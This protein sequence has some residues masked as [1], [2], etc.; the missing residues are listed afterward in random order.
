MASDFTLRDVALV[1]CADAATGGRDLT[2]RAGRLVRLGP[3]L[4]GTRPRLYLTPGFWDAHVHMLHVGLSRERLDLGAAH[5][6]EEALALLR[7]YVDEHPDRGVVW[8]EGWD[9]HAWPERRPPERTEIDAVVADR[10]VIFRRVCGHLAVLNSRA[11]EEAALRWPGLECTGLLTEE[12]AMSLAA[13]WPPTPD[14]RERALLDAQSA[15]L[16]MGIVRVG[17][18]GSAGALDAYLGLLKKDALQLDVD[19]FVK[20]SQIELALQLQ[21]EGWLGQG[22]LHLGGVKVFADGSIGARTAALREPYA[23]RETCGELLLADEELAAILARCAEARL[24]LAV[25]AIGDAAI[26][27]VLRILEQRVA[28]AAGD[29]IGTVSLEHAELI[30][31]TQIARAAELGVRLSLQPNFIARWGEAGGLYEQA[32]GRERW[33]RC[34]PWRAML[35]AQTALCFG[36]DGMPQDPALGLRGAVGHPNESSRL[37]P[38]EALAVYVG[39]ADERWRTWQERDVW[40]L[41]LDGFVLY[42]ADPLRLVDGD[43]TRAPISGVLRRGE[44]LA[45]PPANLRRWGLVHDD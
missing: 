13:L 44:W 29:D 23:D 42:E 8:A 35:A 18:M 14:A 1:P 9:D 33:E 27:Q 36:S 2:F 31:E 6:L 11:L 17:E 32:L 26:E 3:P 41:G 39:L 4:P 10:P 30:D 21:A 15:A 34:N 20:P 22:Y 37:T 7:A 28:S 16:A 40:S 43:L 19:L 24:P 12:R 25:H 5:S 38:E 45:A